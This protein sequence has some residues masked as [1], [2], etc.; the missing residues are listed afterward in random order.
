MKQRAPKGPPP[1]GADLMNALMGGAG[2]PPLGG[3]PPAPTL[4]VPTLPPKRPA[5]KRRAKAPPRSMGY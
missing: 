5:P 3:A 2:G 1:G 4:P